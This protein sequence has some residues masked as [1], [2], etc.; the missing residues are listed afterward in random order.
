M[1]REKI[2]GP[3]YLG[4]GVIGNVLHAQANTANTASLLSNYFLHE[5]CITQNCV[6]ASCVL[7]QHFEEIVKPGKLNI[8][9]N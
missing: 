6:L 9:G 1:H 2:L 8:D 5:I 7:R 3:R 4:F